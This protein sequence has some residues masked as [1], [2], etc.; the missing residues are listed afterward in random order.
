MNALDGVK[1]TA[2]DARQYQQSLPSPDN[3]FP[4]VTC[5]TREQSIGLAVSI[6]PCLSFA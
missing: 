5:L 4:S 6:Q 1:G 3:P 2:C